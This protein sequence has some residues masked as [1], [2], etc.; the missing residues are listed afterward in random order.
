M[1]TS[2]SVVLRIVP[3]LGAFIVSGCGADLLINVCLTLL[4]YIPGHIHAFYMEYIFYKRRDMARNGFFESHPAPGI[5]SQK[6]QTGGMRQ[7]APPPPLQG[8]MR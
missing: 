2:N 3:P 6:V 7:G 4:G 5:Y 8:E 1:Y